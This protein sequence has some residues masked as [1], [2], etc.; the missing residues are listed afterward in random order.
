MAD[1]IKDAKDGLKTLLETISG[2]RV[3]DHVPDGGP[4][5]FPAAVIRFVSRTAGSGGSLGGSTFQGVLSVVVMVAK[6]NDLEAYDEIIK[7]IEPLGTESIEAAVDADNT[8]GGNVDDGRVESVESVTHLEMPWG[9][10][11]V[12]AQFSVRFLK[13]VLS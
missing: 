9:G 5:E 2:L 7:Y 12:A 3:Y 10:R 4:S 6:A 8:W 11:Y 13:S 1:E